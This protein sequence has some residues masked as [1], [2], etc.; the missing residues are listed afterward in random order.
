V[1]TTKW[2]AKEGEEE[3][4]RPKLREELGAYELHVTAHYLR[5]GVK[6]GIRVGAG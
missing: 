2:T 3:I 4:I 5:A 6:R 1:V